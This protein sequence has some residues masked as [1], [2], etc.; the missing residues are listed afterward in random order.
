MIIR[1]WTPMLLTSIIFKKRVNSDVI[2]YISWM[3]SLIKW[4][5][6]TD[7]RDNRVKIFY[8]LI[9]SPNT[10]VSCSPWREMEHHKPNIGIES[11]SS[12]LHAHPCGNISPLPSPK[13]Q[14]EAEVHTECTPYVHRWKAPRDMIRRPTGTIWKLKH[15]RG[16]QQKHQMSTLPTMRTD[17]AAPVV[18]RSPHYHHTM[19]VLHGT[20]IQ[21]NPTSTPYWLVLR[22]QRERRISSVG[23]RFLWRVGWYSNLLT[24]RAINY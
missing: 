4:V 3:C 10:I 24:H 17:F 23:F 19:Y 12:R 20:Y 2:G 13:R 11:V 9:Q 7:G 22:V 18:T 6:R 16:D 15:L 1:P 8:G 14:V 21:I 5:C